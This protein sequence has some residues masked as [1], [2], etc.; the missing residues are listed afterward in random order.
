MRAEAFQASLLAGEEATEGDIRAMP[1][2]RADLI[3]Q[4]I[5][6][7]LEGSGG[8]GAAQ[9]YAPNLAHVLLGFEVT[10]ESGGELCISPDAVQRSILEPRRAALHV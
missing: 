6:G 9:A 10:V 2:P 8:A 1:D 7:V 4:L 3:V 5:S